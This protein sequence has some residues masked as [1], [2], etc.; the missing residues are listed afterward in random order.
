MHSSLLDHYTLRMFN[1]HQHRASSRIDFISVMHTVN[2]INAPIY[3][4]FINTLLL[5]HQY[6]IRRY[7]HTKTLSYDVYH[8]TLSESVNATRRSI[9]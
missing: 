3:Y 4:P 2:A 6:K 5:S 8:M 7:L 9:L 1:A